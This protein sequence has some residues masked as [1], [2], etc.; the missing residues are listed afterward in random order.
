M[1]PAK[2]SFEENLV[3]SDSRAGLLGRGLTAR[4]TF[5]QRSCGGAQDFLLS[6]P[7]AMFSAP[8]TPHEIGVSAVPKGI[9]TSGC[10]DPWV[11]DLGQPS[12]FRKWR[13]RNVLKTTVIVL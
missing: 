5:R 1:L 4:A 3:Q 8:L 2:L 6:R 13:L 10:L 11:V 9:E 7:F 12:R